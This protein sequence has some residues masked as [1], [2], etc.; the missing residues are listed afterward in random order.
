MIVVYFVTG[1]KGKL[2]EV[3]SLAKQYGIRVEQLNTKKVEIQ[4]DD[5]EEIALYAARQVFNQ[6]G[7]SKTIVVEDAG[8]FIEALRGFP[9]PYSSYVYKTIGLNGIL[10]LMDG[11]EDRRA[12]FKAVVVLESPEFGEEVFEGRVYGRIAFEPRGAKGF[13]FDPIFIPDGYEKTFAEMDTEQKNELSHRAKAF[14]DLF[15][16]LRQRLSK[17]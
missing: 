15:E 1:N 11:V 14:R 4:S 2:E 8:L 16:W 9:G 5:I 3:R 6:I 12:Y 17:T 13:G 10:K 7:Q